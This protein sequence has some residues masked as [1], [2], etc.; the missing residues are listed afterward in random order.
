[1]RY[2]LLKTAVAAC[3]CAA[4]GEAAWADATIQRFTHF[5]GVLGMGASDIVST[6]YLQGLKLRNESNLKFTGA[7][8]G[9]LQKLMGGAQGSNSVEILRV[10]ENKRYHLDPDKKTY[11]ESALYTPPEPEKHTE[12]EKQDDTKV[13]KNVLT[14]T[15][16]HQTKR[17]NGFDTH[18]YQVTW[19][20]DTENTKTGEKGESLMT[21]DLWNS[22]DAKL[23]SLREQELAY[24]KAMLKLMHVAFT[25]E[26]AKQYG[27]GQVQLEYLNPAD[28]RKFLDKLGSIQGYPV[29]LDVTWKAKGSA[30]P[31]A[32]THTDGSNSDQDASNVLGAIMGNAAKE[33]TDAGGMTTIFSS[34]TELKSVDTA[35]LKGDLF[36]VPDGYT[37]N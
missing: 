12:G 29:S 19:L 22:D 5:G 3:L 10:D 9:G 34:H 13:T 32:A 2:R 24:G 14:V 23:K 8:L 31:G 35:S 11:Q 30:A 17:I 1:M 37:K 6:E 33:Q 25:P 26:Q 27:F 20:V 16:T 4:A 18:E 21:T 36:S 15:D 7:V 28:T